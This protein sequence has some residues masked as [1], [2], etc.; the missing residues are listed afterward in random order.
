L[1]EKGKRGREFH[2]YLNSKPFS[3]PLLNQFEIF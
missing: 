1:G 2:F 3:N